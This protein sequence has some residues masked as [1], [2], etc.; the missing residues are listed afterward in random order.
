MVFSRAYNIVEKTLPVQVLRR[1]VPRR[2]VLAATADVGHR[3][4][5]ALEHAQ[6]GDEVGPE[7]GDYG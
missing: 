7:V 4:R 1:V 3:E 2:A 5:G 6:E